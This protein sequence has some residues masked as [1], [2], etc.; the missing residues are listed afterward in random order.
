M[1]RVTFDGGD[2][3]IDP[4]PRGKRRAF[5]AIESWPTSARRRITSIFAQASKRETPFITAIIPAHNEQ[6]DI[7]FALE[8]LVR[9]T[10]RIDRI[11][12]IVNGTTDK[13]YELAR[14]FEK[15]FPGMIEVVNN[16]MYTTRS[17]WKKEV[18]SKVEALNYAWHNFIANS[19]SRAENEFVFGCDADIRLDPD[20]IEQLEKVLL[21]DDDQKIG[22]VRCVYHLTPSDEAS[23][24]ELSLIQAQQIDFASTELRD[25]LHHDNRVTILGGQ[26]TLFRREALEK[27]SEQNKGIGPW[28]AVTLVEDAYLTRMLEEGR[29]DG[30][31]CPEAHCVVGAMSTS[32][33]L[34]AQRRKWQNGHLIDIAGDKR[35]ALDRVRWAQQFALG[36][37]WLIRA[38]FVALVATSLAAESFEFEPWWMIPLVL[39]CIQNVLIVLCMRD[40]TPM[41]LLR[42]LTYLLPEI[43]V[44]RTLG[45]WILSLRKGFLALVN[46]GRIDQS[47]WVKQA[48]AEASHKTSAWATWFVFGTSMLIPATS[49]MACTYAFPATGEQLLVYGWRVIAVMAIVSSIFMAIK[50]MRIVKNYRHL[51]L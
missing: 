38:L 45:V 17:G 26:A 21:A 25:Q 4:R 1:D 6:K 40:R 7:L 15:E 18:K 35:F 49:L 32:H 23:L 37:N 11:V 31:V 46:T 44:W 3:F 36:W 9:Q 27:V 30:V 33:A 19:P 29:F 10:R 28:S 2:I 41:L 47:D 42:A 16:P 24:S 5:R 43:Y 48:R 14:L 34:Q 20:A 50:V 39:V 12:V 13:T 51:S 8:S 22:G